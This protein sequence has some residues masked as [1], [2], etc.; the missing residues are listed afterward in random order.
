MGRRPPGVPPP[1]DEGTAPPPKIIFERIEGK[2]YLLGNFYMYAFTQNLL[3][4]NMM[5]EAL[6]YFDSE[7]GEKN[8]R[9]YEL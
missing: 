3:E 9:G 4:K 8:S 1:G 6:I 2:K 5:R 7:N